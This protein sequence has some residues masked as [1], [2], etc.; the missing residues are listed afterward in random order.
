MSKPIKPVKWK[1][2]IEHLMACNCNYG[3]PCSFNAPPT[4]GACEAALAYRVVEGKYGAVSL[5]GLCWVVAA[6]WPGPL[7]EGNGRA[8][9]YLDS[10][11][12]GEQRAALEAIATGQAGGPIGIFM[13]T[14][15][16]GMEVRTAALEFEYDG[17]HSHF[18]AGESIIVVFEPIRNP[19][20]GTEHHA[21]LLLPGGLIA[22]REDHYSSQTL[23]VNADGFDFSY[24]G[25]T[26]IAMQSVWRGP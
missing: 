20:S 15:T 4:H 8:V 11:A 25:R 5:D 2:K 13:S 1:L 22:K 3:C 14:V 18:R 24:P 16:A 19:V 26:A 9:V 17:K 12:Q 7:H 23:R 6:I 10:R 21:T